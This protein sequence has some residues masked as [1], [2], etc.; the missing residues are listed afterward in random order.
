MTVWLQT[1][2]PPPFKN[3]LKRNV[4]IVDA[5][6]AETCRLLFVCPSITLSAKSTKFDSRLSRID[7]MSEGDEI[8]HIR[9]PPV[10]ALM[11]ISTEIGELRP[12]GQISWSLDV[13][14]L[15]YASGQTSQTCR[16]TT[17]TLIAMRCVKWHRSSL[18]SQYDLYVV[19]QHGVLCEVKCWR[20]IALLE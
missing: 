7:R 5:W 16:Q 8:W 17:D 1:L 13:R 11:Y 20:F 15:R 2:N 10:W 19:R 6:Y 4:L 3:F 14:S 18:R 9:S 12:T